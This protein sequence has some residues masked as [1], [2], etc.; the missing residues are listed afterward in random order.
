MLTCNVNLNLSPFATKIA[1]DTWK[2]TWKLGLYLI[3]SYKIIF[4]LVRV[5]TDEFFYFAMTHTRGR[6]FKLP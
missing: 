5:N 2:R 3:F 6:L 4:D 1:F